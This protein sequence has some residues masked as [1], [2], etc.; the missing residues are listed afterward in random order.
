MSEIIG[1]PLIKFR[2]LVS[3]NNYAMQKLAEDN[4]GEGT[5]FVSTFQTG[6]RGQVKNSWESEK[7]K[8]LLFSILLKPHFL[9]IVRQFL[10]SKIVALAVADV[11]ALYVDNVSLKWPNDVYVGDLKIAGI[12]IENIIMGSVLENSVAGIGLNVNQTKFLSDAPNPVSLFQLTNRQIDLDELLTLL[13]KRLNYW[14]DVLKNGR[15]E[16]VDRHYEQRLYRLG[17]RKEFRDSGGRYRGT[18]KG[19]NDIGQ[20]T[21]EDEHGQERVYHFKEVAFI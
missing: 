10:I 12:L 14:Y 6:G 2:E 18:I 20:L 17:V 15:E 3:T 8:N 16:L 5:T 21:V 9:P 1:K 4:A 7:G 19:V 11:V 13:L